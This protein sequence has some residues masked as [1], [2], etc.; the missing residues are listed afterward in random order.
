MHTLNMKITGYD[1]DSQSLLVAFASNTTMSE[2]PEDYAPVAFQPSTMWPELTDMSEV[3][4]RIALSGIGH[5]SY[6][7]AKEQFVADAERIANMR[8]LVGQNI[9]YAVDD[10]IEQV[11]VTPFQEI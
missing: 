1:E 7:V 4:K 8:A 5:I 2:N 10:L 3:I 9:T 6:V 11:V